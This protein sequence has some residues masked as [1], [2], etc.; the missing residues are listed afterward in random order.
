MR[1]P[2]PLPKPLIRA[3]ACLG[4]LLAFAVTAPETVGAE[5]VLLV[6]TPG[7]QTQVRAQRM[8]W[9][10]LAERITDALGE[11]VR[12]VMTDHVLDH[13]E[14]VRDGGGGDVVLDEAHFAD[15][16]VREFDYRIVARIRGLHAFCVVVRSGARVLEP[17]DLW[18]RTVASRPAPSLAA[19]KL[20]ELFPDPIRAPRLISVASDEEAIRQVLDGRVGAAMVSAALATAHPGLEVVLATEEL[21]RM[22]VSIGPWIDAQSADAL[23]AVLVGFEPL[24]SAQSLSGRSL[25]G[26]ESADDELYA[27]YARLLRGTWGY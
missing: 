11:P 16:R 12:L 22:A 25:P 13:W 15:Y 8:L 18:T 10:R 3:A 19:V 21:P 9:R 7:S 23:K 20:L 26:F 27:G 4:W 17:E 6:Q 5:R 24:P 2:S 1:H 14:R